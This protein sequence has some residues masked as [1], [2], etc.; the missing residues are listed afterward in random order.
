MES[1]GSILTAE[2]SFRDF[3]PGSG[4]R[5]LAV[6]RWE[7]PAG[8][9]PK[10]RICLSHGYGEHGERYG[11]T[12]AWLLGEGWALSAQDHA[13]FGRSEG[14]RGD[15]EGIGPFVDDWLAFLRAERALAPDR[16]LVALGHSFGGL[17]A[18]LAALRDP[19]AQ[20][21]LILSSPAVVL[22]DRG[23]PLNVIQRILRRVA[24]H[25]TLD[26]PGN[27]S[28]VCSDAELV[29]RYWA[30]LLCHRQVSAAYAEALA[31]GSRAALAQGASLAC[32]TLLLQAGDDTLVDLPRAL[33]FWDSVNPAI[34]ERHL[35]EGFLHEVFHDRRR[36]VA[37]DLAA[38]W[39]ARRVLP[40]APGTPADPAAIH[41]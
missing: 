34:L 29:R 40:A 19:T 15:A 18:L 25:L 10:G 1:S 21:G 20:D 41:A 5:R 27:K 2:P 28:R 6:A 23:W 36:Q 22:K 3:R 24:P 31:E 8:L 16:P 14:R 32:P 11:H 33:A 37:Q 17:V 38:R 30:D 9:E 13:G 4:G 39:L 7:P 26:L 12:A 35:L